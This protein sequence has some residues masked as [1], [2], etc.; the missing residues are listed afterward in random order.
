MRLMP[1]GARRFARQ[2]RAILV[3][4]TLMV[5]L[6]PGPGARAA[7]TPVG[8]T[9]VAAP[10]LDLLGEGTPAAAHGDHGGEV[11]GTPAMQGTPVTGGLD[12]VRELASP[13]ATPAA[14]LPPLDL[15]FIDLMLPHHEGAIVMSEVA[16]TRA[17]HQELRTM[18]RQII[19]AQ[20]A[21]QA[22]LINWRGA[23]FGDAPRLDTT[24]ALSVFDAAMADLGMPADSGTLHGMDPIA[25]ARA[26]CQ[27]DP[28]FDLAFI[29]AMI[30]HHQGAITMAEV[31]LQEAA[32]PELRSSAQ[33][34]IDVQNAEIDQLLI[35]QE[36]WS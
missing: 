7:Q 33:T 34:V 30:R 25:D 18:A 26:L 14:A 4:C 24:V 8:G 16:L 35:W 13:A 32:H 21:E 9:P 27:V 15:A 22:Q 17:E 10:C 20:E 12:Q 19:D 36:Q 11:S 28:P 23:W 31:A 1:T 2:S 3:I 6:S 29:D 5:A